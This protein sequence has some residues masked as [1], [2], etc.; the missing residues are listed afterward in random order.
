ML[1]VAVGGVEG[2]AAALEVVVEDGAM[3]L[4]VAEKHAIAP[5]RPSML[6]ARNRQKHGTSVRNS[7]RDDYFT[8]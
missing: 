8:W 3:L 7:V 1:A 2:V 6:L 5:P 4:R